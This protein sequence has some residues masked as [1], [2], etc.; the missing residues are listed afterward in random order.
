MNF[1]LATGKISFVS[2]GALLLANPFLLQVSELH[3][4]QRAMPVIGIAG[5]ILPFDGVGT[6]PHICNTVF[7]IIAIL[8]VES[9]GQMWLVTDLIDL[10]ADQVVIIGTAVFFIYSLT[11]SREVGDQRQNTHQL[12]LRRTLV[13]Q[14]SKQREETYETDLQT[15]SRLTS[16]PKIDLQTVFQHDAAPAKANGPPAQPFYVCPDG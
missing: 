15:P 6:R 7:R 5:I 16:S 11:I 3:P 13:P 1:A 12:F 2:F 14:N 8:V 4:R 9:I 10:P